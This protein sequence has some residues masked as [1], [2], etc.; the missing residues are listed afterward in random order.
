MDRSFPTIC[1]VMSL[2]LLAAMPPAHASSDRN[3]TIDLSFPVAGPSTYTDTYNANRDGGRRRHQGTDIF[4]VKGQPVHAAVGGRI[5]FAP[6]IDG[7]MPAYGYMVRVCTGNVVY[8]YIHL[9]NDSPGT[10]DGRGGP[11]AAYA[12][13]IRDGVPVSRGQLL[14]YMGDSGNA[15]DTPTHLHFDIFDRDLVDSAIASPPWRQHYRNPYPSLRL[16]QGA[17]DVVG[18]AMR[19]GHRGE[20]V[21]GWQADLNAVLG[22]GVSVDGAFGPATDTATRRF[23]TQEG[24][25]D[26]GVVGPATRRAM[27]QRLEA[28]GQ[29]PATPSGAVSGSGFPGRLLRLQPTMMRGEDVRAWQAQMRQRGWR[30]ADGSPL[31]VDSIF[32]SD[33]DRAARGLQEEKGLTADGVVG[34]STW[35]AAFGP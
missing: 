23:Q 8:S 18:G 17:G 3:A 21:G 12:P 14:G 35:A 30:G 9:N 29:S 32:G 26:D 11:Q 27:D 28:Q 19:L 31:L 16:A 5:C 6:G 7:S 4:G 33:S 15:E 20:A 24:L 22:G 10:D 34:P 25:E 1:V 13:G 2:V